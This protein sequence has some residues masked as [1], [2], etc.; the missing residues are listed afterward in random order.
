MEISLDTPEL[1]YFPMAFESMAGRSNC[2]CKS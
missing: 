1:A 2:F